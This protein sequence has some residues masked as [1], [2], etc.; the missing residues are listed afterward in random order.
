MKQIYII[1]IIFIIILFG[2][3]F[4]YVGN[5][6]FDNI[7]KN[8]TKNTIENFSADDIS[9]ESLCSL[10]ASKPS[11]LNSKCNSLTENNCNLTS[12]CGW[13]NGNS[14][15]AGDALGSTF[16]TKNG[17]DI[18]IKSYS[19]GGIPPLNPPPP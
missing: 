9:G 15:V 8:K 16:R 4:L 14:C 1:T 10:Y 13:L 2:W 7:D 12:C 6:L 17:K 3:V 11:E 18:D 19:M 5:R